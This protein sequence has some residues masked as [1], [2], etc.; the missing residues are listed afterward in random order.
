MKVGALR[1]RSE[2]F[3]TR[4]L[5]ERLARRDFRAGS[6]ARMVSHRRGIAIAGFAM[7]AIVTFTVAALRVLR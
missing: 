6:P 5:I 4:R 3:S 2:R 7:A 1:V